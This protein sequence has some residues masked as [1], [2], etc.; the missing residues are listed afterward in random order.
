M[1]TEEE[2]KKEEEEK[3]ESRVKNLPKAFGELK[4]SFIFQKFDKFCG[5]YA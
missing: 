3:V 4:T 1:V 2:E 5:I